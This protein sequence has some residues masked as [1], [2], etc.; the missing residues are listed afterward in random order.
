MH[1]ETCS[2]GVMKPLT[3]ATPAWMR[4]GVAVICEKCSKERFVEDF[5]EHAGDERLDYKGYIKAR[6]K[7]EGRSGP[8]R[9]VN[10]SC[11]DVCARGGVT[12]LLDPLG[13][14]DRRPRTVVVDALGGREVLYDAI[15]AELTPRTET[16]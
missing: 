5:P 2:Y 16:P 13:A 1:P 14:P 7:A 10:S 3:D 6:L 11:L 15:V 12:A 9:V 4:G 8:I